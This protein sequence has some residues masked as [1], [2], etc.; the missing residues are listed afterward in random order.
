VWDALFA[1]EIVVIVRTQLRIRVLH[2]AGK[3]SKTLGGLGLPPAVRDA[4]Q[5]IGHAGADPDLNIDGAG[6]RLDAGI[7]PI[8]N[9]IQK[10]S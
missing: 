5:A 8:F 1:V 2:R 7:P 4:D 9:G 6:A 3:L 10:W